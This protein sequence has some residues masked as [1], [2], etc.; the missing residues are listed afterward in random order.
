MEVIMVPSSKGPKIDY[1]VNDF[2]SKQDEINMSC[3]KVEVNEDQHPTLFYFN[4]GDVCESSYECC[5]MC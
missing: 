2:C 4:S 5:R 3:N 1:D